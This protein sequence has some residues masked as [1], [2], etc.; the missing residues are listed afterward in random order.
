MVRYYVNTEPKS[1]GFIAKIAKQIENN[2]C[3][4]C[5]KRFIV[6]QKHD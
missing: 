3:I 1:H 5:E 2:Y 6:G 4:K